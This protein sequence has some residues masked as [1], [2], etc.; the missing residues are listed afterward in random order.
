V[1]NLV[2][3]QLTTTFLAPPVTAPNHHP[4][5]QGDQTALAPEMG[6]DLGA[7]P[8]LDKGALDPIGGTHLVLMAR[9]DP[10]VVEARLG[11]LEQTATRFGQLPLI[12][13]HDRRAPLLGSLRGRGRAPINQSPFHLWPELGGDFLREVLPR[14]KP[15]AH[16]YR[17]GP[18]RSNRFREPARAL[19]GNRHRDRHAPLGQSPYHLQ[20]PPLTLAIGSG[21]TE[22]NLA[23]LLTHRPPTQHSRLLPPAS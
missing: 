6:D 13:R 20:T 1:T 17:F 3:L 7:A 16:P 12:L 22:Q 11:I 5:D 10:E 8:L 23:P 9:R 4:K 15:T 2:L 18:P 14:V 21:E 19:G